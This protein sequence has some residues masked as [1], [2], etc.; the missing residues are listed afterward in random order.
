MAEQP[1]ALDTAF[2]ALATFD[3]GQ[4]AKAL[5]PIDEAVVACHGNAGQRTELEA[6][7]T[8]L[9]SQPLSR[10]AVEYSCRKLCL[11]GTAACVPTLAPLL[12]QPEHSH[13][14]R[15]ALERIAVTAAG[16]ALRKALG[17]VPDELKIGMI[18]SLAARRDGQSVPAIAGVLAAASKADQTRLA[19]AAADALGQIQTAAA[20]DALAAAAST[21]P[22]V[23]AAVVNARLAAAEGFLAAKQPAKA[24]AI[25]QSL[26]AAAAGQPDAKSIE[27]AATRGLLACAELTA[28]S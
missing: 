14:A 8:R 10:A 22:A 4:D 13:M 17:T 25:Y 18:A 1:T 26:A 9:L 11:I 28:A 20:V 24:R 21:E 7:F 5:Q 3:W 27:L 2:A 15:Y 19:V 23:A 12:D 6:R 16:D